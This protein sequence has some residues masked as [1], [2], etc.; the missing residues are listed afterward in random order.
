MTFYS[1][2]F[3][4]LSLSLDAF[5]ISVS[6]GIAYQGDK[7]QVCITALAFGLA[8]AIMPLIGYLL[9]STISA[10]I[11]AFDHWIAFALL[12][13][14]GGKMLADGI[15][16]MKSAE[17]PEFR[18]LSAKMLCIQAIA[19]SIDALAV[20]ITFAALQVD[21]KLSVAII[22]IT[23]FLCCIIGGSIG[24]RFGIYLK[25]FATPIGGLMLIGIGTKILIEHLSS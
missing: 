19:T 13:V 24:K 5:A 23:T 4:A 15:K 12:A 25:K 6:N 14:I 3:I 1:L 7:K 9:G 11:S 22:G 8:Q 21:I 20:G 10:I 17:T 16:E 2:L 18:Q